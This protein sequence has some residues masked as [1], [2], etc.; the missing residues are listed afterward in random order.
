MRGPR[1]TA[2]LGQRA[3]RLPR[4]PQSRSPRRHRLRGPQQTVALRF[5]GCCGAAR[6]ERSIARRGRAR[7]HGAADIV[8]RADPRR[9]RAHRSHE[10]VDDRRG[11]STRWSMRRR[12]FLD[13]ITDYRAFTQSEGFFHSVA[14][15]ADFALQ[16]AL[17]PAS[18][19]PQL[20]RLLAA[21]ATQVAPKDPERRVLGGGAG[22]T[23]A[24]GDLHRAAE[25]P[26]RRGV[27]SV[28]RD[29]DESEAAGSMGCRVQ[30]RSRD[31]QASQ[32]EGVPA[33]RIRDSHD[34]R[35]RRNPPIVD[36]DPGSPQVGA[37]GTVLAPP[38]A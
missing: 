31:P 33:E 14:H 28:V 4:R 38:G 1:C 23:G 16:L 6:L 21:I 8:S 29:G 26:F 5:I 10:A 19:K 2:R 37:L 9:S 13:S 20:D 25:A 36:A 3:G 18:T 34:Q 15:G 7:R 35:R 22:S 11:A 17:N 12:D 32:R 27:E 24:R 30:V